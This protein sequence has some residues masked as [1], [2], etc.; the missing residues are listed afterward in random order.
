[1]RRSVPSL[2][3]TVVT[4]GMVEAIP[5]MTEVYIQRCWNTMAKYITHVRVT[6]Q[7]QL[8]TNIAL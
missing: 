4:A 7:P 5:A 3:G 2:H 1:M 6:I 8:N